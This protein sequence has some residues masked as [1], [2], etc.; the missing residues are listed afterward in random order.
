MR[1]AGLATTC[2]MLA[3]CG[4]GGGSGNVGGVPVMSAPV[5]A[6]TSAP[7]PAPPPS[8]APYPTY[9]Q[10]TGDQSFRTACAA[11]RFDASPATPVPVVPFGSGLTLSYTAAT[12]T[13]VLTPNARDTGLFGSL[14]RSYGPADR[15]PAAP[16]GVVGY[17]R[18]SNGFIERLSIGSNAAG[19]ASPDYV[20]GF[21]ARVP[22]YG[23][24]TSNP[25]GAQ[26][27]CIFGVPTRGDDLPTTDVAY[28]RGGLNG[29][30]IAYPGVGP[31]EAYVINQSQV[32]VGTDA[33]T[34]RITVRIRLVGALL[35][36]SGAATTMTDLGTYTGSATIDRN[37]FY[38]GQLTSPDRL[39]RDASFGGWFFGPQASEGAFSLG[40]ESIDQS[41]GRRILFIGNA[42]ALR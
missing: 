32:S 28:S 10:L 18:T 39:I 15:D 41:N 13:H 29:S 16:A 34:N 23:A 14:P 8:V 17:L 22:L 27:S 9:A 7:S 21:S 1:N 19:G 20:R 35:T 4:G 37:G 40:F 3:A 33:A 12:Q 5:P 2:V 31:A 36:T 42:L 30:A 38:S 26:Y 25:P 11:L 24:T 6:P